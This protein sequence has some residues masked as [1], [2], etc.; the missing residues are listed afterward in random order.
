[1]SE[2]RVEHFGTTIKKL[3]K[4]QRLTQKMLATGIC[5]QSVLSRIE[6]GVEIPNVLVLKNI[7]QRLNVSLDQ[8]LYI[9]PTEIQRMNHLFHQVH[10]YFLQQNYEK[11]Y[12]LLKDPRLTAS[13]YLDTDFQIYYFYLG[14]CELNRQQSFDDA[15]SSF[16]KGLFFTY[17]KENDNIS[18]SEV[19]LLSMIGRTYNQVGNYDK[20]QQYLEESYAGIE[21]LA[22][23]VRSLELVL[24]FY[25]YSSFLFLN[26]QLER[27]LAVANEGVQWARE[28][29]SDFYLEELYRLLHLIYQQGS[30]EQVNQKYEQL[31]NSAQ[32]I[33]EN[34][35]DL[36]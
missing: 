12:R 13:L 31:A 29:R 36:S 23:E 26:S 32:E 5:S 6:N 34:G 18:A 9:Q 25:H 11:L 24:V 20:A 22:M 19:Q 27:A 35:V 4:K 15:L 2:G 17:N 14:T 7:C 3:R 30:I 8:I 21:Q 1:M 16:K 10:I 28:R 33:R